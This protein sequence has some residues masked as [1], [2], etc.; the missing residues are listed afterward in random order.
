MAKTKENKVQEPILDPD[1]KPKW[2]EMSNEQRQ[3]SIIKSYTAIIVK[4]AKEARE[5]DKSAFWNKNQ[6]IAE[7]D[8]SAP[9]N[10]SDGQVYQN[11]TAVM[12]RAVSALN[13]YENPVFLTMKEGN[14]LGAKLKRD[15]E[16]KIAVKG[17]KIPYIKE[18]EWVPEFDK[19][20]QAV[21]KSYTDKDGH[22]K[23]KQ[24]K[25]FQ[26]YKEPIIETTTLYHASQF[27]D[28]KLDKLKERDFTKLNAKREYF[29][30]N[31]DAPALQKEQMVQKL[32]LSQNIIINLVNFINATKT[33]KDFENKN[34]GI[35]QD[36]NSKAKIQDNF[37]NKNKDNA[38]TM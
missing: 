25:V 33:G 5:Q 29:A 9:Y 2:E 35:N 24:A 3:D 34:L 8:Q 19:N 26:K 18:G 22:T 31:P 20:N 17:L 1:F 32:G 6:S 12:L 28:L 14:L 38:L 16:G 30:K 36:I 27:D 23:T 4:T 15:N 13:G 11:T 7:I 37:K 21:M 10:G